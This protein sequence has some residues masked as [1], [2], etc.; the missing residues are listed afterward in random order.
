VGWEMENPVYAMENREWKLK[1]K[2]SLFGEEANWKAEA[3]FECRWIYPADYL[4]LSRK[5]R[6]L[7]G[8]DRE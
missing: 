2:G 8:S 5:T 4:R 3:V 1:R 6:L 7:A